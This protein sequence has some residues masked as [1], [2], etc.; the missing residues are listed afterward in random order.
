MIPPW[1]RWLHF[2]G[3]VLYAGG[4]LSL[5]RLLGHAVRF[6]SVESR[7]D[8]FR[9]LKRMHMF[10][11]WPGLGILLG[12]GL[13]MLVRDFKGVRY[14]EQGYFHMKLTA[15]LALVACDVVV[16]RAL[17]R[18]RAEGPLPKPALFRIVHGI[19]GLALLGA[20]AA[21]TIVKG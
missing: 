16:T 5:T 13:F 20:L 1:I 18:M 11:D 7:R 12:T 21:V 9:V 2:L 14:M 6:P 4:V 17:L 15:V 10:V 19:A 8:A 3:L